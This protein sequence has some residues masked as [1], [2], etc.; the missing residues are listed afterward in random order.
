MR[1]SHPKT[2]T[3]QTD[4]CRLRTAGLFSHLLLTCILC[5]FVEECLTI[6]LDNP[7]TFFFSWKV[8]VHLLNPPTTIRELVNLYS[9]IIDV[10]HFNG[11]LK[12]VCSSVA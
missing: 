6:L 5:F 9:E 12:C 7:R 4:N 1:S 3:M 11:G 2:Q 10:Q 8:E